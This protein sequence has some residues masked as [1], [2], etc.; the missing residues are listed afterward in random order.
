MEQC[1]KGQ[2]Y[3]V[4]ISE[5]HEQAVVSGRD[6]RLFKQMVAETLERQGLTAYTSQKELSKQRP[7]L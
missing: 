6:R 1:R 4:V 5:A 2:G 3:P 7:W